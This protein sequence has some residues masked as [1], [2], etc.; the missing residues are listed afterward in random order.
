MVRPHRAQWPHKPY[1]KKYPLPKLNVV[2][3]R[4]KPIQ[5]KKKGDG[6]EVKEDIEQRKHYVKT[7]F[8]LK[9]IESEF[10]VN[11]K[12]PESYKTKSTRDLIN[13]WTILRRVHARRKVQDEKILQFK[14]S[15]FAELVKRARRLK[16][17]TKK[18]GEI[19]DCFYVGLVAI[20]RRTCHEL[21]MVKDEL[22]YFITKFQPSRFN[23]PS[24]EEI[25][26]YSV[27]KE[28]FIYTRL[29]K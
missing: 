11:F 20:H 22:F 28:D 1:L 4:E 6:T 8:L 10:S 29:K 21:I 17:G 7:P 14:K 23:Y 15:F 13:I 9:E 12:F 5:Q 25:A 26:N 2:W 19:N 27:P 16:F 24:E 18:P 3:K